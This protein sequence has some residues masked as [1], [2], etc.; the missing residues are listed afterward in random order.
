MQSLAVMAVLANV[1]VYCGS[2]SGQNPA[3]R[4]AAEAFGR[5][6]EV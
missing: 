2:G 3:Y 1:C 5:K 6:L 4:Q